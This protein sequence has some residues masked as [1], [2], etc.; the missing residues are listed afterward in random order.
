MIPHDSASFKWHAG[1]IYCIF[2]YPVWFE[3]ACATSGCSCWVYSNTVVGCERD[4]YLLVVVQ[5]VQGIAEAG[6]VAMAREYADAFGLVSVLGCDLSDD[7][8]AAAAAR[9]VTS[10]PVYVSPW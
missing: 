10:P 4:T 3:Q 9:C 7:A 5:V 8:L 1:E 6:E 2:L